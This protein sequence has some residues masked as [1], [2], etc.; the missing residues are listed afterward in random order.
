MRNIDPALHPIGEYFENIYIG[1]AWSAPLFPPRFWNVTSRLHN[2][3]PRTSNLV[4][5]WHN[6]FQQKLGCHRPGMWRFL[7]ELLREQNRTENTYSRIQI[8]RFP[9]HARKKD[10]LVNQKLKNIHG[11]IRKMSTMKYIGAVAKLI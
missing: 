6:R 5:G 9:R 4:E 10:R 11:N 7:L 2:S 3:I 8:D 1:K